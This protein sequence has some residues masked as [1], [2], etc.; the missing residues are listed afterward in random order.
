MNR[1]LIA[2]ISVIV[3]IGSVL[4]FSN[5]ALAAANPLVPCGG[6]G[7]DKCELCHLFVMA[8]RIFDLIVKRLVPAI[9]VLMLVIVGIRFFTAMGN[10]SELAKIK[11]MFFSIFAGILLVLL[12]WGIT[13]ALYKI[14]GAKVDPKGWWDIC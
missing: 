13:V 14:L 2:K 7:Q 4:F 12:A 1:S 10:P 3:V 11:K 6:P 9:A 5:P 8:G